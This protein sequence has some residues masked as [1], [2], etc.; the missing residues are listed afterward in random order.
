MGIW[1]IYI[2][3]YYIIIITPYIVITV[4][5][6]NILI[7]YKTYCRGD[8]TANPRTELKEY[9]A[10]EGSG[11]AEVI[12]RKGECVYLIRNIVRSTIYPCSVGRSVG[13][14][15][16]LR[17]QQPSSSESPPNVQVNTYIIYLHNWKKKYTFYT[18]F[19]LRFYFFRSLCY[20]YFFFF[21]F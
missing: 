3:T 21:F 16:I 10:V 20:V 11:T 17:I 15:R 2:Y 8:G 9:A 6:N 1:C 13:F 19:S 18:E 5:N 14:L 7:T 4:K 12:R